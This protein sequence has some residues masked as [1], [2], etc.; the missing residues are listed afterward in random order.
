MEFSL[1]A[2]IGCKLSVEIGWNLESVLA[3]IG[4]RTES[5]DQVKAENFVQATVTVTIVC[6]LD[7]LQVVLLG[8]RRG[9]CFK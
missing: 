3:T 4:H 7:Q 9:D 6:V 8:G 1:L 5:Y 2:G